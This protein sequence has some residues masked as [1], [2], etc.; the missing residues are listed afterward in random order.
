MQRF[1]DQVSVT[2]AKLEE[3]EL[4][5]GDSINFEATISVSLEGSSDDPEY[6]WSGEDTFS[7]HVEGYLIG[8][9]LEIVEIR[10]L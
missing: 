1:A 3:I 2:N 4:S 5:G 10:S 6:M 7:C 8:D 9:G